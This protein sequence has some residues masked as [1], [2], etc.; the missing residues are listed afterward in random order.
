MNGR[1][2]FLTLPADRGAHLLVRYSMLH[3]RTDAPNA[4]RCWESAFIVILAPLQGSSFQ[5]LSSP[6]SPCLTSHARDVGQRVK[7]SSS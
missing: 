3:M 7:A 5:S 2:S 6:P 4:E 1:L